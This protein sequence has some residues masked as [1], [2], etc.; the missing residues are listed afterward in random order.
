MHDVMEHQVQRTRQ[1]VARSSQHFLARRLAVGFRSVRPGEAVLDAEEGDALVQEPEVIT[2]CLWK[3]P[4]AALRRARAAVAV[5]SGRNSAKA[6]Q[7]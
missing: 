3:K 7:P 2:P 5:S 4:R 6:G 1:E